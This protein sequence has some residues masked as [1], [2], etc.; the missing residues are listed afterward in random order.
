MTSSENVQEKVFQRNNPN[1]LLEFLL[2]IGAQHVELFGK[3][4][5]PFEPVA[6]LRTSGLPDQI[7]LKL[8]QNFYSLTYTEKTSQPDPTQVDA[9][10]ERILK[11]DAILKQNDFRFKSLQEDV[12]RLPKNETIDAL[13][14]LAPWLYDFG[15]G[16]LTGNENL[17]QK[18]YQADVFDLENAYYDI[19][20]NHLQ[21]LIANHLASGF[22]RERLNRFI[23]HLD[24]YRI[25]YIN[26]DGRE[27]PTKIGL[28]EE[29]PWV[30]INRSMWG[31]DC[32]S[33]SVAYYALS[34]EVKTFSVRKNAYP[35]G[36]VLGYLFVA[37]VIHGEKKL[38]YILTINVRKSPE[39][40]KTL[41]QAVGA[42]YG[43]SEIIL[44]DFEKNPYMVNTE[45]MREGM[46]FDKN[47]QLITAT[48]SHDWLNWECFIREHPC[49]YKD[50]YRSEQ[51]QQAWLVKLSPFPYQLEKKS[52]PIYKSNP[53]K[54]S[55][56]DRALIAHKFK[57]L[58][59]KPADR[60]FLLQYLRIQE[61]DLQ[62][63]EEFYDFILDFEDEDRYISQQFSIETYRTMI[64]RFGSFLD[65]ISGYMD[66]LP[67]AIFLLHLYKQ[68]NEIE[69]SRVIKP[70]K[71]L[72]KRLKNNLNNP[73]LELNYEYES[74]HRLLIK[75]L[76]YFC[77]GDHVAHQENFD[78][79]HSIIL[80]LP[81]EMVTFY[82][83]RVDNQSVYAAAQYG[84][85]AALEKLLEKGEVDLYNDRALRLAVENGHLPVAEFLIRQGMNIHARDNSLVRSAAKNGHQAIVEFLILKGANIHARDNE[86]LRLAAQH[87]HL[88]LIKLLEEKGANIHARNDE[89]LRLAA[90]RGFLS[91]VEFLVDK[92]VPI[93]EHAFRLA[94]E[95]R[96]LAIVKFFFQKQEGIPINDQLLQ[97]LAEKS[98]LAMMDFLIDQGAN[99]HAHDDKLLS[100]AINQNNINL[101]KLLID[102]EIDLR[103]FRADLMESVFNKMLK[104]REFAW[105][106]RTQLRLRSLG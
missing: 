37:E 44:P 63:S 1:D 103:R 82:A 99:I 20:L 64:N 74:Y 88:S 23:N 36:K 62:M 42:I 25:T 52:V 86:A 12:T 51:I 93:H 96:H 16:E 87:G 76:D 21:A 91:V 45:T 32:A 104:I 38:P 3:Q 69:K 56:L 49:R 81:L 29:S 85:L 95:H 31:A 75:S 10:K 43:V 4:V 65:E 8:S 89:A 47:V 7:N 83:K 28:K 54:I 105:V 18:I 84:Y 33:S 35:E 79:L 97:M 34:K 41:V 101:I 70:I 71:H 48:F 53:E 15:T 19:F 77:L 106:Q 67:A 40:V 68:M 9:L 24:Q 2:Q 17:A 13:F 46:R 55:S 90:R 26:S 59:T 66:Y 80:H 94:A 57:H 27:T 78:L 100:L 30:S 58:F 6:L 22:K 14:W 61:Q 39:T 60:T 11:S 102:K 72:V 50:Y 73:L 5:F 98:D 92:G